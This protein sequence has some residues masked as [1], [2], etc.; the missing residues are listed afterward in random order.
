MAPNVAP[1][2]PEPKP[3]PQTCPYFTPD[4]RKAMHPEYPD[5]A[6]VQGVY[7]CSLKGQ[8]EKWV[9]FQGTMSHRMATPGKHANP[10]LEKSV[11]SFTGMGRESNHIQLRAAGRQT[12]PGMPTAALHTREPGGTRDGLDRGHTGGL[13][14]G[15]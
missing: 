9:W 10:Q 7:V 8:P 2:R 4:E 6:E 14:G 1:P 13:A 5:G 15:A 12:N 3:K 11:G